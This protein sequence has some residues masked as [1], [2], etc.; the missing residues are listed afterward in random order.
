M[1]GDMADLL[2]NYR[3]SHIFS[4]SPRLWVTS[5][6]DGNVSRINPRTAEVVDEIH[7]GGQ[8]REIALGAGGVW[9]TAYAR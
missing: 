4:T 6:I 1:V 2:N 5:T 8:P 9:V 7:V 3:P